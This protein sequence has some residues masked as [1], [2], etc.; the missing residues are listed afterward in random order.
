VVA[1]LALL[2]AVAAL[3]Y[4]LSRPVEEHYT[5]I[6]AA[7]GTGGVVLTVDN[8]ERSGETYLIDTRAAG[9]TV[10]RDRIR[11][12]KNGSRQIRLRGLPE[13]KQAIALLY[14][15]DRPNPYESVVFT[16]P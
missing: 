14:K 9:R 15:L 12:A 6:G 7:K 11:V 1:A 10:Q 13:R 5:S 2:G 4:L 3:A 16:T 8:H